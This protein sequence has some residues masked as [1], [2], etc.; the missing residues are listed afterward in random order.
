MPKP[1]GSPKTGGRKRGTPNRRSVALQEAFDAINFSVP[2]KIIELLPSLDPNKQA[3]LLIDLME[4]LYPKRKSLEEQ[5]EI[6][7]NQEPK[8]ELSGIELYASL[9]KTYRTTGH[10]EDEPELAECYYKIAD[11]YDRLS[12]PLAQPPMGKYLRQPG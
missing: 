4:Y 2:D 9:A 11:H 10:C 6:S 8:V 5:I 1:K 3:D 12:G 7:S